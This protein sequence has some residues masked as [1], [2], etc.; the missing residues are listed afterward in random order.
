MYCLGQ[1]FTRREQYDPNALKERAILYLLHHSERGL[2]GEEEK[3][4][5]RV[6]LSELN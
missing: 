2:V 5:L 3:L 6:L 1:F 4:V